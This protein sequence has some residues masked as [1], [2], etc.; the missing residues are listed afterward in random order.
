[1]EQL[2]EAVQEQEMPQITADEVEQPSE[3]PKDTDGEDSRTEQ[4]DTQRDEQGNGKD[5]GG[6]TQNQQEKEETNHEA[7]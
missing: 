2:R 4:P 7:R 5:F 1:M 3:I 6:G